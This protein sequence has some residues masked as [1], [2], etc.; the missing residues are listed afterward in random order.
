MVRTSSLRSQVYLLHYGAIA[1]CRQAY[2]GPSQDRNKSADLLG[3]KE[4]T[5]LGENLV[6]GNQRGGVGRYCLIINV[7][8]KLVKAGIAVL[9]KVAEI[10]SRVRF[11]FDPV[12]AGERAEQKER[13]LEL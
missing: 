10:F 2:F 11:P 1:E 12:A 13:R 4:S 3:S 7:A 9:E 8:A 6:P 5:L